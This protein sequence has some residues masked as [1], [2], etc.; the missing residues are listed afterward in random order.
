MPFRVW[1]LSGLM[2][3][4]L[5]AGYVTLTSLTDAVERSGSAPATAPGPETVAGGPAETGGM[6]AGGPT[7]SRADEPVVPQNVT[8]AGAVV[9]QDGVARM[10]MPVGADTR[11]DPDSILQGEIDAYAARV[12]MNLPQ[13]DGW[14]TL[15]A[16][17]VDGFL[18]IHSHRIDI[19]LRAYTL[20]ITPRL[21]VVPHLEGWL[22]DGSTCFEFDRSYAD[23]PCRSEI[24]LLLDQGAVAVYRYRDVEGLQIGTITV[25]AADCRL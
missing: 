20:P 4:A 3:V 5:A 16:I 24:R 21:E 25:S 18:I 23:E 15:E 12:A 19:S 13:A 1:V 22:C 2:L 6:P 11:P 7:R 10:E 17:E 14:D 9:G 8:V